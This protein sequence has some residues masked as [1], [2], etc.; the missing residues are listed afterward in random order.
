M[1]RKNLSKALMILGLFI[2]CVLYPFA[3]A[4]KLI[5]DGAVTLSSRLLDYEVVFREGKLVPGDGDLL[6]AILNSRY[7][8]RWVLPYRYGVAS[9]IFVFFV[10]LTLFAVSPAKKD[11]F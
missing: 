3:T 5:Q 7:E 10:G 11:A 9:G 4:P 8:G 1:N 2:P 6:S